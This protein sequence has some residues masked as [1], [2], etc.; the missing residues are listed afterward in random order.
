MNEEQ[1]VKNLEK[2]VVVIEI[3]WTTNDTVENIR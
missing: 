3:D 2:T 1:L